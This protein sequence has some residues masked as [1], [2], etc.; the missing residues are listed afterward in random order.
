MSYHARR[1]PHL[2]CEVV[3]QEGQLLPTL[4]LYLS[5]LEIRKQA[6]R[7]AR[8]CP[9]ELQA[10]VARQRQRRGALQRDRLP[11]RLRRRAGEVNG[12]AV[13]DSQLQL[14]LAPAEHR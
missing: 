13:G 11:Q 14:A 10:D 12:A 9:R 6:R 2:C 3:G 8:A 7:A 5:G 1:G 4:R